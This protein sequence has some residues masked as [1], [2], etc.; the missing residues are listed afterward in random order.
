MLS[1]DEGGLVAAE[2]SS[3]LSTGL[4]LVKADALRQVEWS[5]MREPGTAYSSFLLLV[6][7]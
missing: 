3:F 1:A 5:Q 2:Q 4:Q 7:L 6:G